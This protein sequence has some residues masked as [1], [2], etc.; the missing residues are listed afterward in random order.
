MKQTT[1]WLNRASLMAASVALQ[2]WLIFVAERFSDA[3]P[4]G[5]ISLYNYWAYQSANSAGIYGLSIDWIYPA[6]AFLPVWLPFWLLPASYEIGWLVM[7][8]SV[9]A[10]VLMM[11]SFAGRN[12]I[13]TAWLYLLMLLLLGPVAIARLDVISAAVALFG[14]VAL[15]RGSER[16]AAIWFTIAGWIKVWPVALFVALFTVTKNRI[17][18]FVIAGLF[19]LAVLLIGFSFGSQSVLGFVFAQQSRGIQIEAVMATG[20]LW[21]A[22]V[23]LANIYFDDLVLTNQI[24]GPLVAELSVIS[25][26]LLFVALGLSQL[27]AI[28]RL[29]KGEKPLAVFSL[30]SLSGVLGLIVFNKVGSPQFM[31]W[32]AVVAVAL[33]LLSS[34][35]LPLVF[36]ALIL[37]LTQLIYPI[38]YLE[39]LAL[40]PVSLVLITIRNALLVYLWLWSLVR[41]GSKQPAK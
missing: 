26:L 5:D 28:G 31:I 17:Q 36:A 37:L 24:S 12:G 15:S 10:L 38:F 2:F 39:L 35:R 13:K 29:R 22:S 23:D 4:F 33:Y 8:W 18:L 3:V 16:L 19:S 20:W 27:L 41:L 6:L 40:E 34:I 1:L 9:N 14:I 30:A 25:N 32:L 21:L 7:V 11:L